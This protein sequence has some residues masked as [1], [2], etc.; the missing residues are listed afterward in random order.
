MVVR[1][2]YGSAL[3]LIIYLSF[4]RNFILILSQFLHDMLMYL[5]RLLS[6]SKGYCRYL[7]PLRFAEIKKYVIF[8]SVKFSNNL[9]Q[10]TF[11]C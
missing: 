4:F 2:Y 9:L 6:V 11:I 5:Q 7:I 3:L 10:N 8:T 1:C